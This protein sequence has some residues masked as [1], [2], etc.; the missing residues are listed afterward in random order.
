MLVGGRGTG[1][2]CRGFVNR[3]LF[4]GVNVLILIMKINLFMG[5]TVSGS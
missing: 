4:K 1:V 2:G 5:C 3:G